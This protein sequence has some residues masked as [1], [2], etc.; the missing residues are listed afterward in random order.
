MVAVS[1]FPLALCLSTS[2]YAQTYTQKNRWQGS[3][4][5]D[6][7]NFFTEADPTHG[8]V[9]YVDRATA[10]KNGL[11]STTANTAYMG[12]DYTSKLPVDGSGGGRQSVRLTSKMVFNQ[13]LFIADVQHMPGKAPSLQEPWR[14]D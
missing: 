10:Q 8:F 6:A 1:L 9:K 2:V 5:F 11:I 3:N 12:V 7:F 4:F 14:R 13:G